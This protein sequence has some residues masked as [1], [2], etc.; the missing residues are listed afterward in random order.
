[1]V[2]DGSSLASMV[3]TVVDSATVTD[4]HTHLFAPELGSLLLCGADELLTFHYLIAESFR[5]HQMPYEQ[6]WALGK[7]EQSELVWRSLFEHNSPL[8]EAAS[9]VVTVAKQLGCDTGD[10]TF[11][12]LREALS[13]VATPEYIA[14][15][16]DLAGVSDIVMT[17]DPFDAEESLLWAEMTN[18][19]ARF[20]GSLRLD[21]L[22]NHYEAIIPSLQA[23]GYEVDAGLSGQSLAEI[24]RFLENWIDRTKAVY[25]AFSVADD[26]TYP[27]AGTRGRI[28]EQ[29]VLPVCKDRK[30][31]LSLM[32]G[33]RRQVN[34][35]LRTAGDS[36]AS[37]SIKPVEALCRLNPDNKFLV[38]LLSREN[39]HDIVVT[40]RKFNN[41]MLFGCW[42]FVNTDTLVEEITRM[43]LEL[44]G[45][46][47]IPQHSDARVLEQLV[48]KWDRAR[49]VVKRVLIDKYAAL[50]NAGWEPSH[51]DIQRDVDKLF[52][53]NF[54][55]FVKR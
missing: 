13:S 11:N 23:Q 5:V 24:R 40:A 20:H 38:T 21:Q 54:W 27:H 36:V 50:A 26:F 44:L 48:Y 28:L 25:V 3:E 41:L 51:A 53:R 10:L 17:N 42:W 8:S 19:D 47:F 37:V 2:R 45:P 29:V 49:A 43:R 39:Q 16:L 35:A 34:P 55:E 31:P 33:A 4:M 7:R 1:M 46:T 32:I 14:K 9:G 18:H 30:L 52:N 15:V 12:G 6:F 22:M